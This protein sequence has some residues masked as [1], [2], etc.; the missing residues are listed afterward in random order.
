MI[1]EI[2]ELEIENGKNENRKFYKKLETLTKT[3]K[4]R[5]RN[6]KACDRSVLTDE[7]G[8]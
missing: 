2:K 1:N 8:Y 5:N 6:S 4:P 3:Y 7:K